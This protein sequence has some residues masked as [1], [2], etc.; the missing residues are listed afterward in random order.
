MF[1]SFV[2]YMLLLPF[3]V[4]TLSIFSFSNIHDLSWGTKEEIIVDDVLA[5]AVKSNSDEVKIQ[6]L[7]ES[8]VEE[9][10]EDALANLRTRRPIVPKGIDLL[11]VKQD[12][13]REIR[14]RVV[15]VWLFANLTSVLMYTLMSSY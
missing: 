2:Q 6:V 3:Y 13:F 5:E 12:Y 8:D 10:Y 11:Q 14:T 7:A 1:T 4:C 15:L 9:A